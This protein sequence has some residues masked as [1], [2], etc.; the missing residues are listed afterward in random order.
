VK[1]SLPAKTCDEGVDE[2]GDSRDIGEGPKREEELH[3]GGVLTALPPHP[4]H[5]DFHAKL[6]SSLVEVIR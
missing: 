2:G 3:N 5:I 6:G 1:P 4:Q